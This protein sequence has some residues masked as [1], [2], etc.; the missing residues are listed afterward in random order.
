MKDA[1]PQTIYLKDY[2]QSD[3]LISDI[4]LTFDLDDTKT[5]VISVM[6]VKANYDYLQGSRELFLNGEE[7]VLK[8]I[9]INKVELSNSQYELV[10][11]GLIIKEV[12]AEFELEIH[13]EINPQEN[14]ALDG[15]YKSG[16]IFCTQNEPEGFRRITYFIDRP[17]IMAVYTTKVIANKLL[18]P[19]LLSNGN[20]IASGDLEDG[21]HF[22]EWLDPFPKPSYLY[23]LVAGDLGL[24]K[25]E[26][27]TMTGRKIALEIYVD[28]G[29]ES[30][31]DHAMKS[32]IN[33]MKWDEQVYGREYDLDIYMI[34]AV[35][36]FNMG[37][38]ENKGLNIFN[39]A[40]V[41]A[42]PETATDDNFAGIEAVIGHEYFH[43]WT[44]NRI[45]CRDW[46]QLT[47][48]EGLTVFR[49][50]EFSSDL[51]SRI[52]NRISNVK[53]LKSRQFVEDAGPTAH[54]IKPSSYIEINNFYTMTIYEKGSEIIRMIHTLLGKEGFRKGTDKYFELFDG[55]AVTTEDFLHAMSIA[56]DNYDFSQFSNWYHQAG[57]PVIDIKTSYDQSAKEFSITLGQSCPATPGQAT[58]KPYHMPFG[59]GLVDKQGNDITLKLKDCKSEQ[60]QLEQNILH[61]TKEV[62]TFTFSGVEQEPVPSLNR[63]FTAPVLLKTDRG[64]GDYVFLMAND[65]DE[66]NRYESA[67]ALAKSLMN[68]LVTDEQNQQELKL[69]LPY[70]EAFGKMLADETIDNAFK[71]LAITIPSE[72]DLL[73]M[74]EIVDYESTHKVR[75]FVIKTLAN[76]HKDLFEKIYHKL[77]VKEEYSLTPQAMGARD[78]KSAVLGF[79]MATGEQKYDKLCFEQFDSSTNMTDEYASLVLLAD[80]NSS[81]KD[82][83]VSSFYK[84]WKHETLVM[85]KWLTA[86]ASSSA[87][88]TFERVQELLNNE[89]YDKSVPNLVRSL[90]SVFAANLTEFNH[91]S[92]RGYKFIA[93]QIIEIDK[94]NPQMAS[95]LSSAFKDYKRLPAHLKGLVKVELDRILSVEGLSRNVYEILSKTN[96]I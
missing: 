69:D 87:E 53:T 25:D 82:E 61:L 18:Y 81:Y 78:L 3:Y 36:A 40:Y 28:K 75:N 15:L 1:A 42:K 4:H 68:C 9:L 79:L 32:L 22:V 24:V 66:F 47:L 59:V 56:N 11:E 16:T 80:G 44:G 41:L 70:V 89:V 84:K 62:E 30:K 8:K 54:P 23:A 67:Q 52:V 17:D 86:Q 38:M 29:N 48:K 92:G 20:P 37:A 71:A 21:K 64:L 6:K 57:T 14:K 93:D 91:S 19:I 88:G 27:T 74:Q 5:Q 46:F 51:N 65:S 45:T 39:S 13:N 43:N 77:N 50:Q 96:S 34:V 49:D 72:G 55:Q 83:A 95:R 31:C 2:K 26:F 35:D 63:G 33:S 90:V 58:K 76:T 73:Q 85:Q 12:P 7:L 94:I 10:E 60:P